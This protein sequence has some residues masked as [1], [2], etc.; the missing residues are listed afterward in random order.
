MADDAG[1]DRFALMAMSQGGPIAV[2]YA[3]RFPERVTRLVFYDSYAVGQRDTSPDALALSE[4]LGQLVRVG[5]GRPEP[6]FRRVF[7]SLMIP[8]ATEEQMRW[9]D[10]LQKV[11]ASAETV[12]VSRKE[13]NRA[14]VTDLLS[15]V[16]QPTL[17][18]HATGDQ[19]VEFEEG[20]HLASGIPNATLVPLD[21]NNHILLEDEPAWA[22]F[23]AEVERFLAPD[24]DLVTPLP[25][26]DLSALSERELDV[27]RLVAQGLSNEAIADALVV[28]LRTVERHLQNVYTKLGLQGRS[29][30]AAA[31]ARLLARG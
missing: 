13:Y 24:R 1:F 7:T 25:S 9:L 2:D 23:V 10:D 15:Q 18:L 12:F 29:A 26:A 11:A 22:V 17:V 31:V 3:V 16:T 21:S 30:R 14:D 5:W 28:S 27:V 20:R 8:E 6:T 19:S 4:T